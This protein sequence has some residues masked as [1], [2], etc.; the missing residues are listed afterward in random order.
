M[1]QWRV[2]ACIEKAEVDKGLQWKERGWLTA[3]IKAGDSLFQT[4][5]LRFE[6][7]PGWNESFEWPFDPGEEVE[8]GVFTSGLMGR[9]AV[10]TAR[11]DLTTLPHSKSLD[12]EVP[13]QVKNAQRGRAWVKVQLLPATRNISRQGISS[14]SEKELGHAGALRQGKR[15]TSARELSQGVS[16]SRGEVPTARPVPRG[17]SIDEGSRVSSNHTRDL[18]TRPSLMSKESPITLSKPSTA[19]SHVPS[20]LSDNETQK[21]VSYTKAPLA[22]LQRETPS[23]TYSQKHIVP[24][25][26]PYSHRYI[27]GQT[28]EGWAYSDKVSNTASF[29]V[30]RRRVLSRDKPT[31]RGV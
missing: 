7:V 13:L 4:R 20:S 1:A 10:G 2:S 26:Q 3:F 27:E 11:I 8:V 23:A 21:G 30:Q 14:V 28:G 18:G 9:F 29:D 15:T 24:K 25:D 5:K 17:P 31:P 12:V 16:H 6:R 22:D 19:S